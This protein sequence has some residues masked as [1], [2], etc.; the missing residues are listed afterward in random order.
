[1]STQRNRKDGNRKY[2]NRKYAALG[3]TLVLAG[4]VH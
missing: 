1:M 4:Q 3:A 2:G